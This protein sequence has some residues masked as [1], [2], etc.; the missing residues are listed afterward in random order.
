MA[1]SAS[2]PMMFVM[3][4]DPRAQRRREHQGPG[5][6]HGC[7]SMSAAFSRGEKVGDLPVTQPTTF[8]LVT[9]LRT[10]RRSASMLLARAD[11][12]IK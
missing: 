10:A 8:E 1:A 3:G 2:I 12:V 4:G 5:G 7:A 9:N 11:E 6:R